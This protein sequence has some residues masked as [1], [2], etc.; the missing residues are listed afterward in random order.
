MIP[1]YSKIKRTFH[2]RQREAQ[3]KEMANAQNN[4]N[5]QVNKE[6]VVDEMNV[7]AGDFMT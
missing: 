5:I 1:A 6:I 4:S 2:C 7:L 3:Q